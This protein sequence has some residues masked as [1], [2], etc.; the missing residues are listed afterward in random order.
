MKYQNIG[1]PFR[2]SDGTMI[3]RGTVYVP[4]D[5]DLRQRHKKLRALGSATGGEPMNSASVGTPEPAFPVLGGR[6]APPEAASG[7]RWTMIMSPDMYLR[8]HPKGQHAPLARQVLGLPE[9]P[10]ER[11]SED[12][13]A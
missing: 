6:T 4:T 12:D 8:L 5:A 11:F 9:P 7:P 1:A 3:E 10:S 2:S 13:G